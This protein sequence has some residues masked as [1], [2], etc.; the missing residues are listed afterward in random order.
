VDIGEGVEGGANLVDEFRVRGRV[1]A[2]VE[3]ESAES[4]AHGVCS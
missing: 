3:E 4:Y 1:T 2:D